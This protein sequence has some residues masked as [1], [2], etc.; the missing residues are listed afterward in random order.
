MTTSVFMIVIASINEGEEKA[1]NTYLQGLIKLYD[2]VS[3]RVMHNY[4]IT[5]RMVGENPVDM[6]SVI[7]FPNREA[8]AEVYDSEEYQVLIRF[9]DQAFRRLEVLLSA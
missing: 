9:R 8:I 6:V 5:S 1:L 2:N 3:A 4:H 7:A